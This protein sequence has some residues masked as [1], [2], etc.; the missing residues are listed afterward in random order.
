MMLLFYDSE[1]TEMTSQRTKLSLQVAQTP[2]PDRPVQSVD[3]E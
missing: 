2:M 1:L 3:G